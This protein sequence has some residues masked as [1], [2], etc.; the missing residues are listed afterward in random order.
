MSEENNN[1]PY[2]AATKWLKDLGIYVG[3]VTAAL[4]AIAN[5]QKQLTDF[6]QLHLKLGFSA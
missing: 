6:F 2:N 1:N 4:I 5:Y 3:A